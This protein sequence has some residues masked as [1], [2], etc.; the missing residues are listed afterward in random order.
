MKYILNVILFIFGITPTLGTNYIMSND[1]LDNYHLCNINDMSNINID[2]P[3]NVT[4]KTGV[5]YNDDYLIIQNINNYCFW[6]DIV[7]FQDDT[8]NYYGFEC[9]CNNR[10]VD[11]IM[12][13]IT[14]PV[15][16]SK[17]EN[18]ENYDGNL[19]CLDNYGS[20][21][22][23]VSSIQYKN[24]EKCLTC[25]NGYYIDY[26]NPYKCLTEN[27]LPSYCG[28]EYT[29]NINN[30]IVECDFCDGIVYENKCYC[31]EGYMGKSCNFKTNSVYCHSNGE[32]NSIKSVCS[33]DDNYYGTDC[34]YHTQNECNNG[35]Y[36]NINNKCKCFHNYNGDNCDEKIKCEYG[37]FN[38]STKSCDCL[39]G[40]YGDYCDSMIIESKKDNH[41]NCIYGIFRDE[42]ECFSGYY[43]E[44][45]QYN[46]CNNGIFNGRDCTCDYGYSGTYC[47]IN[48]LLKCNYNG[49]Y[50]HNKCNCFGNWFGNKCQYI[51]TKFNKFKIDSL[52]N[53]S[54]LE[55]ITPTD[56]I[57]PFRIVG[58]NSFI[59]YQEF[60]ES[61]NEEST[62]IDGHTVKN[63]ITLILS[64]STF[65]FI[66]VIFG[67][68]FYNRKR[69]IKN[70]KK[71]QH[72]M[73]PMNIK[74][75]KNRNLKVDDFTYYTSNIRFKK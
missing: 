66:L 37:N 26:N 15:I 21:P 36:D 9:T 70:N 16:S 56:N 50:V 48:N 52:N 33:C 23:C 32:Y 73:N 13:N 62:N 24:R 19:L 45:C 35:I 30:N 63:N 57:I 31:N 22:N 44:N 27:L 11:C 74:Y 6:N 38:I 60:I 29:Y 2:I 49:M 20:I 8:Y 34:K 5:F 40:F 17:I 14:T 41:Q 69:N 7:M 75:I 68:I 42:C 65:G 54:I 28:E 47:T 55:L 1:I 10:N 43:G 51:Q 4:L 39:K 25:D 72:S 46:K 67:L 71:R 59:M 18:F 61:F 58:N 3:S 64:L 12:N 53:T